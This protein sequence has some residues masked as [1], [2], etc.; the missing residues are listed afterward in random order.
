MLEKN[1]SL[2]GFLEKSL[3]MKYVLKLL[4]I[5]SKALKSP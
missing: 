3:K 2:K 5:H 1:F 4:E